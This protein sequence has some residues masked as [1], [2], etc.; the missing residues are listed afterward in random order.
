MHSWNAFSL[1]AMRAVSVPLSPAGIPVR[2]VR[3]GSGD[4]HFPS[5]RL[6]SQ[7]E[8]RLSPVRARRGSSPAESLLARS[9][10]WSCSSRAEL[11]KDRAELGILRRVADSVVY[12]CVDADFALRAGAMQFVFLP[13]PSIASHPPLELG[14]TTWSPGIAF[15]NSLNSQVEIL[16]LYA[17]TFSK[18]KDNA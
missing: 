7:C 11:G 4:S 6:P 16:C 9:V 2:S 14:A 13:F 15:T 1:K 12:L 8:E 17:L 18:E 3:L 5:S 10:T